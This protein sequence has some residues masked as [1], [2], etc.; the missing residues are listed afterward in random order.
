MQGTIKAGGRQCAENRG[1]RLFGTGRAGS[2]A[3]KPQILLS[4]NLGIFQ[5]TEALERLVTVLYYNMQFAHPEAATN[6]P[7]LSLPVPL[8]REIL[9][10]LML[11]L[12]AEERQELEQTVRLWEVSAC[13]QCVC[14]CL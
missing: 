5:S 4:E 10:L 2:A 8:S 12:P 9:R 1:N 14:Q 7:D 11:D 3:C 6:Q 13:S